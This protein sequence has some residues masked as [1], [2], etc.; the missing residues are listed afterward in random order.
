MLILNRVTDHMPSKKLYAWK[1]GSQVRPTNIC[2]SFRTQSVNYKCEFFTL[3][4]IIPYKLVNINIF[5]KN[6][7]TSIMYFAVFCFARSRLQKKSYTSK[8]WY[9]ICHSVIKWGTE[10]K[11]HLKLRLSSLY[12]PVLSFTCFL[13]YWLS[14][15]KN[16]ELRNRWIINRLKSFK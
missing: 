10:V 14:P 12:F 4:K 8:K 1:I 13:V 7:F 6:T 15:Q 2:Y 11:L 9:R 3:R 16:I 5:F